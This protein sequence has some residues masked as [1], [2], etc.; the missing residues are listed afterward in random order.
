MTVTGSLDVN[1][2]GTISGTLEEDGFIQM[3]S[4]TLAGTSVLKGTDEGGPLTNTGSL[5]IN[6]GSVVA[7]LINNAT[8]TITN[9]IKLAGTL[10]HSSGAIINVTDDTGMGT[11]GTLINQGTF[12]QTGGTGTDIF[13]ADD[14]ENLGGTV[15][16]QSGNFTIADDAH[17]VG[18]QITVP[19]GS[20]F[21][22]DD[23]NVVNNPFGPNIDLSGTITAT[24]G[25]H[26]DLNSGDFSAQG[27]GETAANAVLNFPSGMA[28]VGN[29]LFNQAGQG[30][31]TNTGFLDFVGSAGH[32]A[33][34]F[35][36][37]GTMIDTGTSSL[38]LSGDFQNTSTG[39]IN[40]AG[41]A[42]LTYSELD[43][44]GLIIKSAGTGI[45]DIPVDSELNDV[46]G[47]IEVDSGTLEI[48]GEVGLDNTTFHV[49]TG[50]VAE[51]ETRTGGDD[52]AGTITGSGGGTV[53][54]DSGDFQSVFF[55]SG[56]SANTT[57]NFPAGMAIVTGATI[58]GGGTIT[59][60]GFLT[61]TGAGPFGPLGITN[62]GT[63]TNSGTAN[64]PL[65]VLLNDTSGVIDLQTDAGLVT[66][67]GNSTNLTNKGL[68]E[69][70][71]GSGV[72]VL[73]ESFFN[74]GGAFDIETGTISFQ[75]GNFGYIAGPISIATGAVL[76][77]D[78]TAGVYIQGTLTS[79]GGGTVTVTDGW[80][81]GPDAQFGDDP[82]AAAALDFAPNVL[83]FNGGYI[84]SDQQTNLINTGSL[85]FPSA[86]DGIAT[87]FNS[88]T[89]TFAGDNYIVA[90]GSSI[91]NLPGG[92]IDFQAGTVLTTAAIN[93]RI[94]NQG[95]MVFN[96]GS[97]A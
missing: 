15:N 37:Q 67:A 42:G 6:G 53:R 9:G 52:L 28:Q 95:L 77:F 91:N 31:L 5:T 54:F 24:G 26:V 12:N 82:T 61:Y 39:I 44:Q 13:S 60:S 76:N 23:G 66:G 79:T 93:A 49:S 27:P 55:S 46:G 86:P 33:T 89:M 50:A 97:G 57:L 8:I 71:G 41:D 7:T 3:N 14:F 58:F 84:E 35:I 16:I 62:E 25:G 85:S 40:L 87:M 59:N 38:N 88:G 68:V 65:A 22:F 29:V 92:E 30:T 4:T 32:G 19:S 83:S 47:T 72:S 17:L 96:A 18:G 51:F 21:S 43:N 36:N 1:T 10:N 2:S 90:K 20:T 94:D 11:S 70:T 48:E 81:D 80:F 45:S 64:L 75:A 74:N 73:S 78:T 56:G 69:K 63:V 34:A